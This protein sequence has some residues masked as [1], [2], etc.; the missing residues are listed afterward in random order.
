MTESSPGILRSSSS[1]W[2][3]SVCSCSVLS[4][5]AGTAAASCCCAPSRRPWPHQC[6]CSHCEVQTLIC[7][8]LRRSFEGAYDGERIRSLKSLRLVIS[9]SRWLGDRH[10]QT[11][12]HAEGLSRQ[13]SQTWLAGKSPNGGFTGKIIY[14]WELSADADPLA[15]QGR[16]LLDPSILQRVLLVPCTLGLCHGSAVSCPLLLGQEVQSPG[17][18]PPAELRADGPDVPPAKVLAEAASWERFMVFGLKSE[19]LLP[20]LSINEARKIGARLLDPEWWL[21]L[22]VAAP[23]MMDLLHHHGPSLSALPYDEAGTWQLRECL[24]GDFAPFLQGVQ[25]PKGAES[26]EV[27]IFAARSSQF[28]AAACDF[29]GTLGVTLRPSS[30]SLIDRCLT[31]MLQALEQKLISID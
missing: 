12:I 8:T 14:R 23:K 7:G 25:L 4:R 26:A 31:P 28:T 13:C 30:R 16:Q 27:P 5:N 11:N 21:S 20:H 9:S 15:E 24:S 29:L 6:G 3:V 18:K 19:C 22:Q 10:V 2:K 1:N 17:D